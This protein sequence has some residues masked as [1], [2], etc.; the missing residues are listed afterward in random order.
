MKVKLEN[1]R[2]LGCRDLECAAFVLS[3]PRVDA[4]YRRASTWIPR[5]LETVLV[6]LGVGA[7]V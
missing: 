2:S 1:M 4:A 5:A 6:G 3:R 7:R